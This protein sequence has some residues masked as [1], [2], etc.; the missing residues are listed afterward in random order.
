MTS[1]YEFFTLKSKTEEQQVALLKSFASQT[2]SDEILSEL[3]SLA[4]EKFPLPKGT[5]SYDM[6]LLWGLALWMS[7]IGT[8]MTK[9]RRGI[10]LSHL[11]ETIEKFGMDFRIIS[12]M[13]SQADRAASIL[14]N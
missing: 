12:I 13:S 11:K 14:K 4:E 3:N 7:D 10:Y 8:V 1:P 2:Y 9:S 6:L 5:S